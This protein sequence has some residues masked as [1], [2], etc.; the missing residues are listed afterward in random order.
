MNS[1]KVSTAALHDPRYDLRV[2]ERSAEDARLLMNDIPFLD[3]AYEEMVQDESLR[4]GYLAIFESLLQNNYSADVIAETERYRTQFHELILSILRIACLDGRMQGSLAFG[5]FPFSIYN[6]RT[7]GLK[8]TAPE[9]NTV[10][11]QQLYRVIGDAQQKAHNLS[12]LIMA[13][14][15]ES[16][17]DPKHLGC[18]AH[19]SN[20][21]EVDKAIA[22]AAGAVSTYL[23]NSQAT[24]V[25]GKHDTYSSAKKL[26]I[27]QNA[28]QPFFDARAII[29]ELKLKDPSQVFTKGFLDGH[30]P[31]DIN[32]M[33]D[34]HTPRD[35]LHGTDRPIFRHRKTNILMATTL[36]R[37]IG[38]DAL[39][40]DA[41]K[42][43]GHTVQTKVLN[44][45]MRPVQGETGLDDP[46]QRAL[47]YHLVMN[48]A[49]ALHQLQLID[50][51]EEADRLRII[52]HAETRGAFGTGCDLY[53][54]ELALAKP[55]RG[56]EAKA[57]ATQHSVLNA[58]RERE[59]QPHPIVMHLNVEVT[60]IISD[61]NMLNE[62]VLSKLW[63]QLKTA[64]DEYGDDA[65]YLLSYSYYGKGRFFPVNLPKLKKS[66]PRI[67]VF[68]VNLLD[69]LQCSPSTLK[70]EL[71]G[72]EA[73]FKLRMQE[74]T[75]DHRPAR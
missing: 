75:R 62:N 60:G 66:Y 46:T 3:P 35:L 41:K 50:H 49:H 43:R 1:S 7:E 24:V 14:G 31:A 54:K 25:C 20:P 51:L 48:V 28:K 37:A 5:A 2:G 33:L 74:K 72:R 12:A 73:F 19:K 68:P 42:P 52:G 16:S 34:G 23:K 45:I 58:N 63:M 17:F 13:L 22:S 27:P 29:D 64:Y 69:Q 65:I 38:T 47:V 56:E 55:G 67:R 30:L 26:W 6:L 21:M 40:Y 15:H 9:T 53:G 57:L 8:L 61:E 59:P 4:A 70:E 18:A 32:T 71:K 39:N 36:A 10:F 11:H 44:A